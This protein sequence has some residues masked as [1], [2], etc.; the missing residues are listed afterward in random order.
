MKVVVVLGDGMS[1]EPVAELGGKTPL[2]VARTP[3]LDHMAG[4]GILGLTRTIPR[5][6]PPTCETGIFAVLGYDPALHHATPAALEAVARGVSLGPDDVVL[7]LNLVTIETLEDGTEVMRD[8]TGGHPSA[9]EGTALA[10]DLARMVDREG[11]EVHAGLSY[12]HLL[13]WRNGEA[14]MRT[15]PAH[16][17][18]EKPIARAL[19]EGPGA[20][21]LREI[22]ATSRRLFTEHPVCLARA[23]RG[24]RAP[25]AA[26]P[27]G[28]GK[29]VRLPAF[30]ERFTGEGAVVAAAD[31]VNGIAALA[32]LT[33]ASVPTATGWVDTDFRGKAERVLRALDEHDFL[34]VHVAAPDEAA[35]AGDALKKV[36]A[37]EKLDE[38]TIGPLLEG[39][40][41][42][43][44]EWRML[45]MPDHPSSCATRAH[46]AEPVPFVVYVSGDEEKPRALSRG[47][48][49][50][51]ARD[52]G[53]FIPEAHTLLERLLRR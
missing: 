40:R 15:T 3:N 16:E 38:E 23:A 47:Y 11:L 30:R 4:R 42:R 2:D 20:E 13:V 17:L 49:E 26:W 9:E 31:L 8:P 6:T 51:D 37:I 52:Q 27:W 7:R 44:G 10:R 53:I 1:D 22:L 19:P 14:G 5:G 35:H 25:N 29:R 21:V 39:L 32:G 45:I 43:G 41:A 33:R 48:T 34:F 36:A 50:R 46:T 24:E 28:P 18:T 12:R